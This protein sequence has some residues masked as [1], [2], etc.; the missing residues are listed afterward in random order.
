MLANALPYIVT[1]HRTKRVATQVKVWDTLAMPNERTV[2][3]LPPLDERVGL[4]LRRGTLD[5]LQ[6]MADEDGCGPS[7]VAYI[8]LLIEGVIQTRRPE[9]FKRLRGVS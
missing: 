9:D 8:R 4:N 7:Q 6:K 5:V 1:D 2:P 3:K